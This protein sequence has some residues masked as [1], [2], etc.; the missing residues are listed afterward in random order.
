MDTKYYER[1]EKMKFGIKHIASNKF[2]NPVDVRS[3]DHINIGLIARE[4]ETREKAELYI[5]TKLL[6]CISKDLTGAQ[7]CIISCNTRLTLLKQ[8]AERRGKYTKLQLEKKEW[9]DNTVDRSNKIID[10]LK[11]LTTNSFVVEQIE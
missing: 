11:E 1:G 6:D 9:Y 7:H 5:N 10:F 2:I 4:F 3:L 8:S